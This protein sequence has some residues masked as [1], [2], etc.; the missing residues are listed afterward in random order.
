MTDGS[1]QSSSVAFARFDRDSSSW[2]TS[3]ASL[4]PEEGQ[5][6]AIS[7]EGWPSS[8][9]MRSGAVYPL[10]RWAPDT[11]ADES[12]SSPTTSAHKAEYPTPSASP[13]GS[14]GN[15]T[16]NNTVSR[17]RP[18][19]ETMFRTPTATDAT[20]GPHPTPN[21]KAGQH[22][23]V[24][25][26]MQWPTQENKAH[27][28]LAAMVKRTA[29]P[30]PTAGDAKS[31][32]SRNLAGSKAHAGVSLTDT[33]KTGTSTVPRGTSTRPTALNPAWV[34]WLMG[35]PIGWTDLGH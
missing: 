9:S 20:R 25:Q 23:L 26:V 1:G 3:Q 5:P 4:L 13:Y 35:F 21:T 7:S 33:V 14:S 12:F 28:P 11:F 6:S 18:S 32:G 16:G 24:T 10:P 29:W 27:P 30:T 22:S 17:G 31:S 34:E 19:L 2:R 8:G 15:G